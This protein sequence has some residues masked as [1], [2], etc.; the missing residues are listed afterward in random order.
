MIGGVPLSGHFDQES[1]IEVGIS[2]SQPLFLSARTLVEAANVT[3][4]TV[5]DSVQ[6][7]TGRTSG[8]WRVAVVMPQD[9]GGVIQLQL[10]RT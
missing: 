7:A 4:G 10:E 9:D 1:S 6:H 2:G 8:P 3:V 5:F